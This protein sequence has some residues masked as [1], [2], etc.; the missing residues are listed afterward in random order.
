[1]N[2]K[3][4]EWRIPFPIVLIVMLGLEWLIINLSIDFFGFMVTVII[5]AIAVFILL[6]K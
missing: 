1:M 3:K 5:G 6:F 4:D 2:K